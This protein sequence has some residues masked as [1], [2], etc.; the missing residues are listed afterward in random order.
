MNKH[1]TIQHLNF[2]LTSFI[3]FSRKK[4]LLCGIS[5]SWIE[6]LRCQI[7]ASILGEFIAII[8]PT[9]RKRKLD[10]CREIWFSNSA[11]NFR[12]FFYLVVKLC[13]QFGN[14]INIVSANFWTTP[15]IQLLILY[16]NNLKPYMCRTLLYLVI[17]IS[18]DHNG[19][20]T[21]SKNQPS[22]N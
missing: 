9:A 4:L 22:K 17:Y 5:T 18:Q 11:C 13:P 6:G 7:C 20:H 15:F 12:F 8:W 3:T 21:L 16:K 10:A 14:Y 2:I 19:T 1:N